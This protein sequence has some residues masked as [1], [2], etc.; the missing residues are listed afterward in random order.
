MRRVTEGG[1]DGIKITKTIND[2][3]YADDI[4]IT[5]SSEKKLSRL[6]QKLDIMSEE[7]GVLIKRDI[8]MILDGKN[9]MFD[10]TANCW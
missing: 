9:E 2:L 7:A 1:E 5:S 6:F 8:V 4:V 10:R 3:R